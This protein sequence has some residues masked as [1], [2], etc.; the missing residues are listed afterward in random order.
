MAFW[1]AV[2]RWRNDIL[3]ELEGVGVRSDALCSSLLLAIMQAE[4]GG[5]PDAVGDLSP[6]PGEVGLF[7][8]VPYSDSDPRRPWRRDRPTFDKLH[9]P[10]F[11]IAW[12]VAHLNHLLKVNDS[13]LSAVT[14]WKTGTGGVSGASPT[15]RKYASNIL[16]WTLGDV[17]P[18]F[19]QRFAAPDLQPL[20]GRTWDGDRTKEQW[21]TPIASGEWGC[22]G[23]MPVNGAGPGATTPQQ[24][25]KSGLIWLLV[26]A[27]AAYGLTRK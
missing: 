3:R 18:E 22:L 6:G 5:R 16:A 23:D 20:D 13:P 26:A 21:G 17:R 10:M 4:S 7:Q 27:A 8:V 14:A 15:A 12:S 2:E 1:D 24:K 19:Q 25:K 11:N 9:D